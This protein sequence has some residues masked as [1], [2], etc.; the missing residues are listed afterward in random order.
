MN[1]KQFECAHPVENPYIDTRSP[2]SLP[3]DVI[4]KNPS[5]L[6]LTSYEMHQTCTS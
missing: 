6:F 1:P 2:L 5:F 4:F 3:S